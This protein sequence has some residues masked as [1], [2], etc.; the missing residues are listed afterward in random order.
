MVLLAAG[1]ALSAVAQAQQNGRSKGAYRWVDAQGVTHYSDRLPPSAAQQERAQIDSH[2]DVRR[3]LPAP[4]TDAQR[5]AAAAAQAAAQSQQDYDRF[6]RQT[7]ASA[8]DIETARD[9]RLAVVDQRLQSTQAIAQQNRATLKQ[10]DARISGGDDDAELKASR[11]SYAAA[12]AQDADA[13]GTLQAQRS[14]LAQKFASD[15]RRFR[16]LKGDTVSGSATADPD[17]PAAAAR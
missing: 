8:A 16:Q 15:L 13:V 14:A 10:L 6:L 7:Y 1:L 9:Q 12:V 2:G 11:A 4:Q 3:V 5:R 17:L